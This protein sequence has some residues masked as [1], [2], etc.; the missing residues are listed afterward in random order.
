MRVFLNRPENVE[1]GIA[2]VRRG[3]EGGRK[4]GIGIAARRLR[5]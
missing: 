1:M 5:H 4:A 2:S 3:R